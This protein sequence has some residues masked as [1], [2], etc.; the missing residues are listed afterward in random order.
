MDDINIFAKSQ[1]QL[2]FLIQT[3]RIFSQDIKMECG[4]EKCV[5]FKEKETAEGIELPNQENIRTLSEK[6]NIWKYEKVYKYLEIW[7]ESLKKKMAWHEI[8]LFFTSSNE[9]YK[10]S[11]SIENFKTSRSLLLM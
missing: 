1:I 6:E 5:M 4:I 2:E 11:N 7:E 8:L 10:K 9:L 3:I